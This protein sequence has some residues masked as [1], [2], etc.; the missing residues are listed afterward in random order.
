MGDCIFTPVLNSLKA[1]MVLKINIK[2][3]LEALILMTSFT[4]L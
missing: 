4:S 3:T 2:Y 1:I